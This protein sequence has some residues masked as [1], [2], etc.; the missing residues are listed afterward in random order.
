MYWDIMYLAQ[1]LG[2][3]NQDT[4]DQMAYGSNMIWGGLNLVWDGIDLYFI[5]VV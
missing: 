2:C 4:V 5:M 3:W 1:W